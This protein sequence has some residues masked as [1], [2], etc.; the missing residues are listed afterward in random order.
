ME[1]DESERKKITAR[2]R[3]KRKYEEKERERK[4]KGLIAGERA[5]QPRNEKVKRLLKMKETM[6][7]LYL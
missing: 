7:S 2:E 4:K 1:K 5:E 3:M 6:V